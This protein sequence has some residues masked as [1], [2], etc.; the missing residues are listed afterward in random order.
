MMDALRDA[1]IAFKLAKHENAAGFMAEGAYHATGA[2]GI[3][4]ATVGPGVANAANVVA[5]AHQDRVPLMVLTGCVDESQ[6]ASY[7]HQVFD[8]QALLRPITKA[9]FKA[10]DGAVD[11]TAAKALSI[12]LDDRPGPVHIDIPISLAK[13]EQVPGPA[14]RLL[15][16]SPASPAEGP[17]LD[18]ARAL[19]AQAERPLMVAGL[20]VLTQGAEPAVAGFCRDLGVPLITT[21]KAKGVL[22]EDDP[23]APRRRRPVAGSRQD[24]AAPGRAGGPRHRRRLRPHR[25]ALE[26]DRTLGPGKGHRDLRRRQQPLRPSGAPQLRQPRGQ[27]PGGAARRCRRPP[28]LA[29]R[30]SGGGA[31]GAQG[32]VRERRRLGA[33]A[34]DRS[35]APGAA[36]RHRRDGGHR[37]PS[38]PLEP[39]LGMPRAAQPLAVL[40]A[41]HHGL[42]FAARHG[43]QAGA[44]AAPGGRLHRRRRARDGAG[45]AGDPARPGAAGRPSWCS[46]TPPWRSSR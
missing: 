27:G 41:L 25:D 9:S 30:R 14:A 29:Q 10:V 21:Y 5:N 13:Q 34:S 45:R 1:G 43:L 40:G 26:L 22:P 42:R 11:I 33:D 38:H 17:D 44:A 46:S 35:G 15:R 4:L 28:G 18:A 39:T 2:P 24:P 19:L 36:G 16:P 3:L 32:R 6:A 7:S 31:R 20:D 12:A 37:G 23:L 8:H